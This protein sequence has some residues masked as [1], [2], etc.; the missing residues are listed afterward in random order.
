[1]LG[2]LSQDISVKGLF[3]GQYD[4]KFLFK[5]PKGMVV[6]DASPQ[7]IASAGVFEPNRIEFT[8][9]VPEDSVDYSQS[10]DLTPSDSLYSYK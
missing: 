8:I 9:I 6:M 4:N 10:F 2:R 1:M 5:L 7:G 3:D